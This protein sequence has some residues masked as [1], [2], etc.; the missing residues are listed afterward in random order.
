[1]IAVSISLF[2]VWYASI[3]VSQLYSYCS[4]RRRISDGNI[5]AFF[6]IELK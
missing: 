2:S 6:F 4:S 3:F 1:M 5:P